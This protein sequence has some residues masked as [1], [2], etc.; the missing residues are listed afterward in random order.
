MFAMCSPFELRVS[1]LRSFSS[2]SP[3]LVDA[4][5]RRGTPRH[6]CEEQLGP[7]RCVVE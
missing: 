5:S 1:L 4:A 2:I 6:A 7:L 3:I